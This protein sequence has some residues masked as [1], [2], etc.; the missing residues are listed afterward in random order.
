MRVRARA[1]RRCGELLQAIAPGRGANQNIKG[2]APPNVLTRKAA[3]EQAG[4]SDDQRKTA[5]RL[6]AIPA[7]EFEL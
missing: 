2:D 5:L 7:E 4:L 3:A 1:I 6:A